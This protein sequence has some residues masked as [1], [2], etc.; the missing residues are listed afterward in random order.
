MWRILRIVIGIVL[1]VFGVFALVTPLTPG[2]WL[3]F[4][5]LEMLG[6]GFLIPKKLRDLWE[7]SSAKSWINRK[8]IA[9]GCP[10][11]ESRPVPC[12]TSGD[13]KNSQLRDL[14]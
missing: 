4:I 10:P 8:L 7:E 13:S 9:C 11:I 6:F 2:A 5:G 14:S 1:V 12:A 3:G